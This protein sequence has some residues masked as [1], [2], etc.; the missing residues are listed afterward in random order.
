MIKKK[1]EPTEIVIDLTGP[2]GNVYYLI[3]TAKKFAIQLEFGKEQT[4]EMVADMISGDY[5]H[6]VDVFEKH[7]GY[8]VTLLI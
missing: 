8:F 1:I 2:N 3:G 4:D 7:F 6:L 5:D